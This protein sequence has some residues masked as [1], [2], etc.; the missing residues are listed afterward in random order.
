MAAETAHYEFFCLSQKSLCDG[1]WPQNADLS[2]DAGL[3]VVRAMLHHTLLDS[4]G[5]P[6]RPK[7]FHEVPMQDPGVDGM[8]LMHGVECRHSL[9]AIPSAQYWGFPIGQLERARLVDPQDVAR[10]CLKGLSAVLEQNKVWDETNAQFRSAPRLS[11]YGRLLDN[12]ADIAAKQPELPLTMNAYAAYIARVGGYFLAH[13]MDDSS[14]GNVQ[15]SAH[16]HHFSQGMY[17]LKPGPSSTP[18]LY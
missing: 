14:L 3:A 1:P 2:H 10:A 5:K 4:G 17:T 18:A 9:M 13:A 15:L 11:D 8:H 12:T 7:Q 6:V 16:E